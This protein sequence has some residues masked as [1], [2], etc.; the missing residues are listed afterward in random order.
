MD[1]KVLHIRG[2]HPNPKYA[3]DVK[4][5]VDNWAAPWRIESKAQIKSGNDGRVGLEYHM[6]MPNLGCSKS[7]PTPEAA[8]ISLL[9]DNGCTGIRVSEVTEDDEVH[10]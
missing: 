9:Y 8:A 2:S 1:H 10:Y 7:F 3:V 5:Q 4:V 6:Y